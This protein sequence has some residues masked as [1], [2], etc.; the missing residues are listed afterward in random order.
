[1]TLKAGDLTT[2]A[3]A[4]G[5]LAAPPSQAV[6]SGL[7]SRVS[8]MILGYLNRATILPRAYTEQFNGTGTTALVLPHWPLIGPALTQLVIGGVSIPLAPQPIVNSTTPGVPFGYRFQPSSDIPPGSAANVELVGGA[9]FLR[10]NQN[11]YVQYNAGY[12]ISGEAPTATPWTPLAPWGIWATDQ[13]VTYATSGLVLTPIPSGVPGVGQYVA[14]QPD[15][16]V[17]PTT[18]YV[19]NAADIATGVIIN[20]G[21]VPADLEQACIEWIAERSSYRTRVGVRSQSLAAQESLVYDNAPIP[22]YLL[23]I[24]RSYVSV[25]PPAIGASV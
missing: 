16:V 3:D 23:P 1:V 24:L 25:L 17:S 6:L 9:Y 7:I 13:G 4:G 2:Y 11:V 19:F 22:A 20:Y 18:Q 12:Q 8:R 5:Y 15:L 10:G 21:F 14:P